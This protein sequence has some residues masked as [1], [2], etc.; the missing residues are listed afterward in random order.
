MVISVSPWGG[1]GKGARGYIK[2]GFLTVGNV[3][4]VTIIMMVTEDQGIEMCAFCLF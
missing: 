4:I 3:I 2:N 1:L